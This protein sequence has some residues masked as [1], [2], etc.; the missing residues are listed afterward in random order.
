MSFISSSSLGRAD[1]CWHDFHHLWPWRPRTRYMSGLWGSSTT[2]LFSQMM[3]ASISRRTHNPLP[4]V[5]L[6]NRQ[7]GLTCV[8]CVSIHTAR[9]VWKNYLP[10]IN[11]IVF[12]VD[13]ADLTRLAESKAELDV[14]TF[15]LPSQCSTVSW[16]HVE[17]CQTFLFLH[18]F[19]QSIWFL[20]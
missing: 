14:S 7:R 12:L 9:R 13:C 5:C 3:S 20:R 18:I 6:T 4:V 16:Q 19:T 1:N 17:P 15:Y 11:G 2:F 8:F 10:A